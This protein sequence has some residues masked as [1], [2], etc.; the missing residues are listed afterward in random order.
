MSTIGPVA[1]AQAG[2]I[3][4]LA[5]SVED[6]ATLDYAA[7][8]TVRFSLGIRSVH[9]QPI[10]SVM[11]DTQIQ[12][13]ARRRGYDAAAQERLN[14]L[15]GAP[16]RWGSTLRTLLWTRTTTL[17]APFSDSTVVDLPVTCTY[18][19]EVIASKYFDALEDG[20]VPLEFLFS[21]TVFYAG[22]DGR[23]QTAR[24]SWEQDAEYR[25]PVAVWKQTI[26]RYFPD[27][28]WL[29]LRRDSFDRLAAYKARNALPTWEDALDSLLSEPEE[30]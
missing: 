13:A 14:E 8:P 27:T 18:D 25:L 19:L 21:G 3:P 26:E 12:I 22:A 28:A 6:A 2:S 15:F 4:E 30:A 16:E 17:V 5:F 29:R 23:L 20:E 9:G 11:L 24:I 7:V 1:V 10:R